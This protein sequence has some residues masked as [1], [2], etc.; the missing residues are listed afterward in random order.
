MSKGEVVFT[1]AAAAA[2][3]CLALAGVCVWIVVTDPASLMPGASGADAFVSIV[4]RL[5]VRA[6]T[7]ALSLVGW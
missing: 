5:V 1:T 4:V 3:C 6:T 2:L 7:A